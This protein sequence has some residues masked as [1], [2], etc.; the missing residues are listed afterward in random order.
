MRTIEEIKKNIKTAQWFIKQHKEQI[1]IYLDD[2]IDRVLSY[3]EKIR[4]LEVEIECLK[5]VLN[6]SV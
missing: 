5:W 3:S 4:M 2:D 1:N 6:E